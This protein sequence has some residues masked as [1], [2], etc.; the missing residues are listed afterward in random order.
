MI[1]CWAFVKNTEIRTYK[2]GGYTDTRL[3]QLEHITRL[4]SHTHAQH[5]YT[6][7]APIYLPNAFAQLIDMSKANLMY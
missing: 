2:N 4:I 5:P 3:Q 7:P 6:H 1:A